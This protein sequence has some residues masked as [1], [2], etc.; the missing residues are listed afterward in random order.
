MA[1]ILLVR[2]GQTDENVS[3]RISGQGSA[4]LN[5]RGQ[6]QAKLAA[7]VLAP[8]NVSRL[9]SSP[10][11]RALETATILDAHLQ[12]GIEEEPDLREVGYGD[13]EG[14]TFQAVR[15]GTAFQ[16]ALNDPINAVFPNGESLV[17]VQQRGVR[18]VESIR[19]GAP[20][21]VVVLVSHGNVI[22]MLVAHYLGMTFNDYRRITIDNGAISVIELF[23]QWIRVK[24]VNFVPQVGNL[25]LESFYATWQKTQNLVKSSHI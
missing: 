20:Q 25:W 9:V 7:Q 18:V 14:Q 17:S 21:D 12:L 19:Q 11:V 1:L 16:L 13:W 5:G 3:G 15:G 10:V 22:R 23:D 4:P 24:A 6:E 8:L 2:H